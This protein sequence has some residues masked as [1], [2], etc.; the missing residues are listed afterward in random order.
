[1]TG[2]ETQIK[3]GSFGN[4][5]DLLRKANGTDTDSGSWRRSLRWRVG[6]ES[7]PAEKA[8]DQPKT[9]EEP[10]KEN[11]EQAAQAEQSKQQSTQAQTAAAPAPS[12][13]PKEGQSQKPVKEKPIA[14]PK[15]GY[16]GFL[17]RVENFD[18]RK[19]KGSR[20]WLYLSDE[21]FSILNLAYGE[22]KLSAV[23]NVLADDHI[24]ECREDMKRNI[25]GKS[26]LF[27]E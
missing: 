2:T 6:G 7:P 8:T 25:K 3:A 21:A 17:Q 24:R 20:H 1:M 10:K 5:K 13:S 12:K 18:T 11:T 15:S 23:L 9:D 16:K 22:K 4:I 19:V 26:G 27:S 14:K